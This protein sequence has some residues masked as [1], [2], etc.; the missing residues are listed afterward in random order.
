MVSGHVTTKNGKLYIILNYIDNDKKRQQKW[1]KT[2]L[3]ARGNKRKAEEMLEL[4]REHYDIEQQKLVYPN[5]NSS[6]KDRIK[7]E[8]INEAANILFGDYL[9]EWLEGLKNTL[10]I[11][12][13]AGYKAKIQNII[14]PYF[15]KRGITLANINAKVI[16]EFYSDEL[17]RVTSST[18]IR[19]HANIRK[20]LEDAYRND[21]IPCNYADKAHR[22][23]KTEHVSKYY[24]VSELLKLFELV[25]GTKI[26]FPVLMAGYYGL[27]REEIVGLK[28]ENVNF[29]EKTITI[30]H[31]ITEYCLNGKMQI[32]AKDRCKTK[33]SI[34]TLPLLAE[35]EKLLLEIKSK[36]EFYK[37][38]FGSSYITLYNSYIYKEPNGELI[39]PGYITD[40]FRNYVMKKYN[41][42][43]IR[44]HDLR[45]TCATMLRREGVSIGDIQ[46]WLG[47]SQIT[48]T[49]NLYAH[50]EYQMHLRS[51]NS[52]TNA[53]KNG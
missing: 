51:A 38:M 8:P 9:I 23:K 18:V 30:C 13:Y 33:K 26:E 27:R 3:S 44:F 47:H 34:R 16:D 5:E 53:L 36:E 4:Y 43:K 25:K 10:E 12:T 15:N 24:T 48:T 21:L 49:E 14:A 20:A 35:I 39:R 37:D 45:H 41:L 2:G 52:I 50:F 42:K 19:Y 22:P 1:I 28:W 29:E 6:Q 11:S 17:T 40:H 32:Q 46:K 7:N 31:T